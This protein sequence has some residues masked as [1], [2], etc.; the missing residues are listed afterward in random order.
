MQTYFEFL[1][2]I[3]S[4]LPFNIF[5]L[6]ILLTLALY[7]FEDAI[8]GIVSAGVGFVS[9]V[10][11]FFVGLVFYSPIS[12]ILVSTFSLTKGISDAIAFLIVTGLSFVL[13]SAL[14]SYL[15]TKYI[16][17][18]FPPLLDRTGGAIFGFLSFFFI[19]SFAIS[20]LLSF[21]V[22]TVI[23][24]SIKSSIS[25][26]FLFARTQGMEGYVR[27]V[28]GGAIQDTINFLTVEP[29]SQA[30]VDLR[31]KTDKYKRDSKAESQMLTLV[32]AERQKRGLAPLIMDEELQEVARDH[33]ADML[34]RGYFS[35]YTPEGLSPFDRMAEHDV[36]YQY[37]GENLAFA[38]DVTI[39]MDGLMKSPGHKA[40]ILSSNYGR[41]GIGVLD[42]G[43]YGEMFVQE[44]KD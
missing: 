33:A 26:R 32:N 30:S 12:K 35:H 19:S 31:F 10:L 2:Q 3:F 8:F 24:N 22:S 29:S 7:V 39:A 37:A 16:K 36:E 23:K 34:K 43:I 6:L 44:F 42:A 40:N 21:P 20:L 15:R 28:F 11:A 25:G 17:V 5:D 4:L 27:Q 41:V 14:F 38:P 18:D 9:I 13:F 1:G